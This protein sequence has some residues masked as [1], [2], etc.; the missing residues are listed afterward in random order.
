MYFFRMI[1]NK[2]FFLNGDSYLKR[3]F[4]MTPH[5]RLL[6]GWSVYHNFKGSEV[7]P[8]MHQKPH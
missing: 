6:V 5:V 7:M 3:N 1:H 8:C 4:P 2:L